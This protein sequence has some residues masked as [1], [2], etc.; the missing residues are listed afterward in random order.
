MNQAALVHWTNVVTHAPGFYFLCKLLWL[1][2]YTIASPLL[3]GL[4]LSASCLMHLSETKHQLPGLFGLDAHSQKLLNGDRVMAVALAAYVGAHSETWRDSRVI[5]AFALL[6]MAS[7]LGELTQSWFWYP[8]LHTV[9][10][11]GVFYLAGSI[12]FTVEQTPVHN[13]W[14]WN[15][16]QYHDIVLRLQQ[17]FKG[18]PYYP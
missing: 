16:R 18:I 14:I 15:H 4:S 13:R 12:L 1:P 10:H 5:V 11:L 6:L 9:W 3:L 2:S 17:L 7:A 8:L